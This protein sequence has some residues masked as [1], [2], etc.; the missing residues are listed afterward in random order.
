[1]LT[2]DEQELKRI[3]EFNMQTKFGRVSTQGKGY[4]ID[5]ELIEKILRGEDDDT[6]R[7]ILAEVLEEKKGQQFKQVDKFKVDD[8]NLEV[9]GEIDDVHENLSGSER[10]SSISAD[11]VPVNEGKHKFLRKGKGVKHKLEK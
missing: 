2:A 7:E 5:T 8:F 9:I 3:K 11:S 6:I 1:M 10:P 4:G